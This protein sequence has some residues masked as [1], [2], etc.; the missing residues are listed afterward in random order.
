MLKTDV[1]RHFGSITIIAQALK[2]S[3]SAISQWGEIVPEGTA[4]KLQVIT[5]GQLQ[6]KPALYE[7]RKAG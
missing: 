4:Y 3:K 1:L 5:G 6:V 7:T 2:I